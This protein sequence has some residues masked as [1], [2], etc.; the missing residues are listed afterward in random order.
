[1]IDY[2]VI[3][4]RT[5]LDNLGEND[6]KLDNILKRFSCQNEKDLETFLHSKAIIYEKSNIGKTFLLVDE[7]ELKDNRIF[8][9]RYYI[10]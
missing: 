6:T 7:K 1:M 9:I 4:L 10:Y 2:K 8:Y 3:S 5:L